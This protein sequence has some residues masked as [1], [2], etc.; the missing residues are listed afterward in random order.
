LTG[1]AQVRQSP[2]TDLSSVRRKL[3]YDLCYV[4]Q[5][6][7]WLDFRLMLGTIL[8]CFGVPFIWIGRI[9]QLPDPNAL[10]ARE[11]RRSEPEL[12]GNALVPDS[13]AR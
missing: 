10:R 8:K 13:Y 12:A 5:I 7:F 4:E 3:N 2:D 1:L 11:F 6:S 9:L